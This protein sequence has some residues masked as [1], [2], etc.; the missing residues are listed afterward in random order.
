MSSGKNERKINCLVV[1]QGR[2]L[3]FALLFGSPLSFWFQFAVTFFTE[4]H[5]ISISS[6]PTCLTDRYGRVAEITVLVIP[7]ALL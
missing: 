4:Y 1:K 5:K 3:P 6:C 2:P 7:T